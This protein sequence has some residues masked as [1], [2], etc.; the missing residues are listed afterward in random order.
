MIALLDW[1]P[2]DS[3]RD[4]PVQRPLSLSSLCSLSFQFSSDYHNL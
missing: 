2:V 3:T 1:T 4:H